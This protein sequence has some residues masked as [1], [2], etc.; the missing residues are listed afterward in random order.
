MSANGSAGFSLADEARRERRRLIAHIEAGGTTDL[1]AGT[2]GVPASVYTDPAR[3]AA[4]QHD[5][6]GELPL[7]AGLS[8]DI[9]RPGDLMLF[10]AAGSEILLVRGHDGT[11]RAFL[12]ICRHRGA[13]LVTHCEPRQRISCPFHNWSY[14]LDGRLVG[15]PVGAAFDGLDRAAHGLLRVPVAEWHGMIFVIARPGEET[16]DPDAVVNP[17]HGLP[18]DRI[19]AD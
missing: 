10:D 16:I 19:L 2:L 1:A 13:R 6:F 8:G 3:F 15:I 17:A 18:L 5:I 7:L 14:D 4:E 12:N 11:V 9:A